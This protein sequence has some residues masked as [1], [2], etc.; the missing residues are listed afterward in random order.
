[1]EV[2]NSTPGSKPFP[3]M[4]THYHAQYEANLF[5]INKLIEAAPKSNGGFF[6]VGVI[7]QQTMGFCHCVVVYFNEFILSDI[8]YKILIYLLHL[9]QILSLV[10]NKIGSVQSDNWVNHSKTV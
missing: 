9:L 8:A 5:S 4:Y 7:K 1:M 3:N 10:N 6:G 2:L